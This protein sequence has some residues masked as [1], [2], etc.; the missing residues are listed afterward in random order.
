MSNNMLG[1]ALRD[2]RGLLGNLMDKLCGA[3]GEIWLEAFKK[4]L[5]KENPWV[6]P[7][8][9]TWKTIRLGTGLKT[10]ANFLKAFKV[11]R[12][13]VCDD[14]VDMFVKPTFVVSGHEMEVEL[15]KVTVEELGFVGEVS[16]E[17]IY[18]R[19]F[20]RGLILC[21]PEVGP[22]LRLQYK[23]QPEDDWVIIAMEPIID[24]H[25][26]PCIFCMGLDVQ[27]GVALLGADRG[28]PEH[29][30]LTGAQ[31]VFLE[32]KAA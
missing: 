16:L 28:N 29:T 22:Q 14:M 13:R 11:A 20:D 5:R 8:F 6:S 32:R 2:V 21:P 10:K 15:I 1:I 24:S 23:D 9:Q 27:D 12:Q 26:V 17:N 25:G 30:L 4:F 3:D 18:A 7:N 31:L 19:A